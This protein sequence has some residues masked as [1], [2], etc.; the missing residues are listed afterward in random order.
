MRLPMAP[1]P[2]ATTRGMSPATNANDVIKIGRKRTRAPFDCRLGDR[3]S[4]GVLLRRELDDEHR[5][6]AEQADEHDQTDLRIDVIGQPH[7]LEQ[8]ERPEHT[9]W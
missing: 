9:R 4:V 3:E 2:V 7:E 8:E 6:L 5:I 1:G